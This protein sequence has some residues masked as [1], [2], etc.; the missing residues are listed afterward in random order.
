MAEVLNEK[1]A[2]E[3]GAAG[4]AGDGGSA[5]GTSSPAAGPS[6]PSGTPEKA[7]NDGP[8]Q[9]RKP[10]QAKPRP[11]ATER[12]YLDTPAA[13]GVYFKGLNIRFTKGKTKIDDELATFLENDQ[14]VAD[15]G[16]EVVR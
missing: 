3:P 14:Y 5:K 9:A 1:K 8:E 6:S 16:A 4:A 15:H 10:A 13:F 2:S 11:P 7:R 12:P